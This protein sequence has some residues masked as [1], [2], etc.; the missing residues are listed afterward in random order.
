M[1]NINLICTF[2]VLLNWQTYV[3][4]TAV[5][6]LSTFWNFISFRKYCKL[7]DLIKS[8]IKL[9]FL[10]YLTYLNFL[11]RI[12]SIFSQTCGNDHLCTTTTCLQDPARISPKKKFIL[13][14]LPLSTTTSEQRPLFGGP[15][16][17]Y[18]TQVRLYFG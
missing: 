1:R 8:K 17:G 10:D 4:S 12:T 11:L 18:C 9:L 5:S 7:D 14:I 3:T 13:L 16:G 6:F 15:I 2:V